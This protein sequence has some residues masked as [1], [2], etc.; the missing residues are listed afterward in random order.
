[1]L[2]EELSSCPPQ[3]ILAPQPFQSSQQQVKMVRQR[4]A[5]PPGAYQQDDQIG[6]PRSSDGGTQAIAANEGVLHIGIPAPAAPYAVVRDSAADDRRENVGALNSVNI[7]RGDAEGNPAAV[8]DEEAEA[9]AEHER[10]F[11]NVE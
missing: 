4:I 3:N 9:L 8:K 10:H 11:N 2:T 7:V 1:M 6:V 5:G